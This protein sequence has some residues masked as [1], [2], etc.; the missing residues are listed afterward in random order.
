MAGTRRCSTFASTSRVTRR[1][2]KGQRHARLTAALGG[3][4]PRYRPSRAARLDAC[5]FGNVV[6]LDWVGHGRSEVHEDPEHYRT[7]AL[8][9]DLVDVFGRFATGRNVIVGH[10]YG[11]ALATLLV[12]RAMALAPVVGVVLIG[13]VA[14]VSTRSAARMR[15]VPLWVLNVF[16]FVHR[17]GGVHSVSVRQMVRNALGIKE[18]GVGAPRR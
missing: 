4:A 15:T 14:T 11:T 12:P 18:R 9:E 16:R 13:P 7:Q 3:K 8:L 2:R 10:S 17:L 6:A 1:G 5:R